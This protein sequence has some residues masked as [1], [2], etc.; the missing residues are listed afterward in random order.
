MRSN[1]VHQKA[2][3]E[4]SPFPSVGVVWLFSFPQIMVDVMPFQE[5]EWYGADDQLSYTYRNLTHVYSPS[6]GRVSARESTSRSARKHPRS[7]GQ[8]VYM[9]LS[10]RQDLVGLDTNTSKA[11]L[12]R[13]TC[14]MR[15]KGKDD[16]L[17]ADDGVI[18][19]TRAR[20]RRTSF[21][22]S[23]RYVREQMDR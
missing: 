6:P 12:F 5:G 9:H 15:V 17:R 14:G 19:W 11:C 2:K 20:E 7:D 18:G 23:P 22:V 21:V 4:I 3:N 8:E 1:I 10:E 13:C 16:H